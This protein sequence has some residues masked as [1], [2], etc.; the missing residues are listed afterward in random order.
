MNGRDG[1]RGE[2]RHKRFSLPATEARVGV[3]QLWS[4]AVEIHRISEG[5]KAPCH[6]LPTPLPVSEVVDTETRRA[7]RRRPLRESKIGRG[8]WSTYGAER[9][10]PM[11][12]VSKSA[13]P[14]AAQLLADTLPMIATNCGRHRMVRR[15]RRFES[16]RGLRFVPAD[17][18]G[19]VSGCVHGYGSVSSA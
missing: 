19:F 12:T 11:A 14:K 6:R 13:I 7:I 8:T 3:E 10:Q 5:P 2:T 1:Q 16:V 4:G 18:P 15:G 9:T 17:A